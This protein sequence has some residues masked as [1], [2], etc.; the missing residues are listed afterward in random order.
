ME[1][2]AKIVLLI[3]CA[4]AL[5]VT[6]RTENILRSVFRVESPTAKMLLKTKLIT[7][8]VTAALFITVFLIFK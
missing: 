7:L 8:I 5:L 3:I 2:A 6:F 4:L 1:T